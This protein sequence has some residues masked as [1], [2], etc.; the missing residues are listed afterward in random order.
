MTG[1]WHV[2][3]GRLHF[4]SYD[5]TFWKILCSPSFSPPIHSHITCVTCLLSILMLDSIQK[6]RATLMKRAAAAGPK[7][8]SPSLAKWWKNHEHVNGKW[9]TCWKEPELAHLKENEHVKTPCNTF[10]TRFINFPFFHVSHTP[11]TMLTF[12][13]SLL[14]ILRISHCVLILPLC[15]LSIPLSM[16]FPTETYTDTKKLNYG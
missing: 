14:P 1:L 11:W 3:Q 10:V 8:P 5:P 16:P 7:G 2:N 12:F 9:S 13:E 15:F 4:Y 6:M